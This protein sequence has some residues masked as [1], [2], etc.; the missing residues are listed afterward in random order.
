MKLGKTV[1]TTKT[2]RPPRKPR[3]VEKIRI[4][5]DGDINGS[6]SFFMLLG[7]LGVLAVQMRGLR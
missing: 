4:Y 7:A 1:R 6:Y 2:P 3:H 5:P